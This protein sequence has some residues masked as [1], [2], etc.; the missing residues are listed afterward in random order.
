[1][2]WENTDTLGKIQCVHKSI[3]G[4]L[5]AYKRMTCQTFRGR[6]DGTC[7]YKTASAVHNKKNT[8]RSMGG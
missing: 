8:V 6:C 3:Y 1:M 5:Y 2:I 7:P 4:I